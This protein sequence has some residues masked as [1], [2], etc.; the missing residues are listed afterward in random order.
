MLSAWLLIFLCAWGETQDAPDTLYRRGMGL[1]SEG[2]FAQAAENF[3]ELIDR[4]GREKELKADMEK[5]YYA[6]GCALYNEEDTTGSIKAFREY[7]KRYPEARFMDEA[8]F[9]IGTALQSQSEYENAI[10]AYKDLLKQQPDS[11]FAEDAAFQIGICYA[12]N[13]SFEEAGQV[14]REFTEAY[15]DSA[16]YGQASV[17]L[18]QTF[19]E[20]EQWV[21]ALEAL[22]MAQQHGGSLDQITQANFLAMEIGDIAFDNTDY[23]MALRAYR[24]VRTRE[25]LMRIQRRVTEQYQTELQVLYKQNVSGLEAAQE[26]FR[27]ETRLKNALQRAEKLKEKLEDMPGY[28]ASLF[29]RIGRCFFNSDRFW[30]ARVAFTRVVDIAEEP[31]TREA[32]LFDLAL[33][34][35]RQRK[36]GKLIE[37]ANQYLDEFGTEKKFIENG[38]VPAMAFM[39]AEAY[40]NMERYEEAEEEMRQLLNDYPAHTQRPAIEFYLAL[41]TSMQ[42]RFDEGIAGFHQWLKDHPEHILKPDVEYWLAIA[43]YYNGDFAVSLPMLKDYAERYPLSVYTPEALY[44]AALC[45]YSLED[46]R[47]AALA[48][49]AWLKK[50]PDHYYKWEAMVT[51]GDALAAEGML[52]QARKSYLAV[53]DKAGPFY[54]M[55]IS[56]CA[57]VFKAMDTPEAYRR[58]A[59]VFIRYIHD[60]PDSGNIIDAAFQA[61]W[62]LRQVDR[63]DEARRLYWSIIERYGNNRAWEGFEPLFADLR[64]LYGSDVE[65]FK[66]ELNEYFLKASSEGRRTLS[67]RLQLA[68]ARNILQHDQAL[69]AAE[70]LARTYKMDV[71]GAE[72]MAFI[73]DTFFKAG[74]PVRGMPY[75]EQLIQDFPLSRQASL[76]HLRM[77]EQAAEKKNW[78]QAM[79]ASGMAVEQAM[80]PRL[81]MQATFVLARSL[82]AQEQHE[83]AVMNYNMVLAS[84]MTPRPLKSRALLELGK[85]MEAQGKTRK[86]IPYYQRVYVLY[87]AYTNEVAQ[88]YLRSAKA[89]E[90]LKDYAAARRT[91]DEMLANEQLTAMPEAEEA[92][93][94]LQ[95]LGS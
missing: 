2:K 78:D 37:T 76:A 87:G 61:G 75:L 45:M 59:E 15:P 81:L 21:E 35:S 20:R 52:D 79:Q 5:V 53:T 10:D 44:R 7:V 71:L 46:F 30:E 31:K 32:A 93:K 50:Y 51:R 92:R 17:I 66:T 12:S 14:F 26:Y 74:E 19:F 86:A 69:Q 29:H 60:N 68:Q 72:E 11:D 91:Y 77:A 85:C 80:E 18:A 62:A 84:R 1:F 88:A 22:D 63:T 49:G 48:L 67:A 16:L 38:R 43:L 65:A 90:K 3:Q 34:L 9:R 82:A 36:F 27:K 47:G 8:F 42:E 33:V 55:A 89:F 23:E 64:K 28:D 54:F 24:R 70:E 94:E 13:D 6:L 95:R 25:A 58:M 73:G 83:E 4:F 39:R 57:R 56:Q 40:V 41:S